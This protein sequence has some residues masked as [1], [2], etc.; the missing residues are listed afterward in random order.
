MQIK[1]HPLSKHQAPS[2]VAH[3]HPQEAGKRLQSTSERYNEKE[4]HQAAENARHES[5]QSA[6]HSKEQGK[7]KRSPQADRHNESHSI[8]V[9]GRDKSFEATMDEVI[10][11]LPRTLRPFSHFIHHPVVERA[12]ELLGRTLFR[13]N[14]VLLGGLTAFIT[15]LCLY[16]YAKFAGFTLQGSETIIAFA[17]GWTVGIIFDF[18][19]AMFTGKS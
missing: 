9:S 10:K 12:S 15:V 13:P 2:P 18:F 5:I 8:G 19:R 6:S 3:E 4:A 11:D 1:A 16:F 17:I 14:A 7:E